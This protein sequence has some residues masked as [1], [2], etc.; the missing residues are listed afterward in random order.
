MRG[1]WTEALAQ[2]RDRFAA[3][4]VQNADGPPTGSRYKC[5]YTSAAPT[6]LRRRAG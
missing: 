3:T 6:A 2:L 1:A 5:E 4:E